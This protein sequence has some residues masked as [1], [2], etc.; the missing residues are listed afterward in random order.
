MLKFNRLIL[1][2]A[3]IGGSA[4]AQ[5]SEGSSTFAGVTFGSTSDKFSKSNNLN[6]NLNSPNADGIIGKDS[7]CPM[8]MPQTGPPSTWP[9]GLSGVMNCASA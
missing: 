9:S 2:L 8:L 4:V 1:A 6:R 7:T 5:A 3:F